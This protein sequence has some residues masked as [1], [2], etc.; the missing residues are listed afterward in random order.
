MQGKDSVE[1]P[2][3]QLIFFFRIHLVLLSELKVQPSL[4]N[5]LGSMIKLRRSQVRQESDPSLQGRRVCKDS[6]ALSYL[7]IYFKSNLSKR[8]R[9]ALLATSPSLFLLHSWKEQTC[10]VQTRQRGCVTFVTRITV[11]PLA[12]RCEFSWHTGQQTSA[13]THGVARGRVSRER[14]ALAP[15][16]TDILKTGVAEGWAQH[17]G[18]RHTY[19]E[20][21]LQTQDR[22]VCSGWE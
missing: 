9:S 18:E 8:S 19:G 2:Q 20:D 10:S 22:I 3:N 17:P 6:K 14:A 5:C 15:P 13:K 21:G 11:Q 4:R 12:R 1:D 16:P 7:F